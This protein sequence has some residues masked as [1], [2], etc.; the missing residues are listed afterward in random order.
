MV[1][2]CMREKAGSTKHKVIHFIILKDKSFIY[3][4]LKNYDILINLLREKNMEHISY[5]AWLK[6]QRDQS[7]D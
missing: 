2:V 4:V 6:R 3:L 7:G 5:R 1:V